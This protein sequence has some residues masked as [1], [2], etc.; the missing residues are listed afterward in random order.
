MVIPD[1]TASKPPKI[2]F[3]PAIEHQSSSFT[4]PLARPLDRLAAII[5]DVFVLLVPVFILLS[6]PF[7]RALMASFILG[8]EPTWVALALGMTVLGVAL[9][10]FYQAIMHYFF[11]ATIGKMLF[12]LRV[13]PIF[14]NDRLTFAGQIGRSAMWLF[15]CICLGFPLLAVFSNSKRRTWHDRFADT[16]V[17]SRNGSFV[18]APGIWERGLV[19]GFFGAFLLFGLLICSL[20]ALDYYHHR[21]SHEWMS[22]AVD[23]GQCEVVDREMSDDDQE[24]GPHMRLQTAMSLYA[25]GLADRGCLDAEV[26]REINLHIPVGPITYLAQAFVNSDDAEVSNSYLDQVCQE[27]PDTI[28]CS[29]SQVVSK[30]S[31]EDWAGV[32]DLLASAKRGSGYLEVWAVRHFMKQA[33]YKDALRYLDSL[34]D[35]HELAE[36]SL[37]QR[38]KALFDS[39][40]VPEADVALAQAL[41]TLPKEEGEDLS[42]WMCAQQLQN[43][44]SAL[45]QI[46]CHDIKPGK[47]ISEID[48]ERTGEALAKVMALECQGDS[49]VDY[50]TFSES[51]KDEDWQLF[52]RANLKKQ[53]DDEQAAFKLYAELISSA[54]TPDMLRVEALRRLTQ[55]ADKQQM[56]TLVELWHGFE[57][58]EAWIKAGN[59][60]FASFVAQKDRGN[61][62]QVAQHLIGAEAL[63]P[64]GVSQLAQMQ[65]DQHPNRKPASASK[66]QEESE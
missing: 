35:H 24:Q 21:Y 47:E 8:A 33:R 43:G 2:E 63:S 1:W 39:Y 7:K 49:A 41:P 31:D 61:A 11:G 34:T 65:D 4:E 54:S 26:E 48:F 38:V 44:C 46:A 10:I 60:L 53:K 28:E 5:I 45:T 13:V 40:S 37:V 22:A 66:E 6:A 64:N 30:W 29:M 32:E 25:A 51:V 3:Q 55:F 57:S 36:F 56:N 58:K 9:V 12:N 42:A 52:F 16:V 27:A 50:L 59:L 23:A 14:K 15:E 18:H 19:R 62:L 17:I 20:E